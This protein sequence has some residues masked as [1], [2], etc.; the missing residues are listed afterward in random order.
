MGEDGDH[1]LRAARAALRRARRHL[2]A[3]DELAASRRY[4]QALSILILGLEEL[5]KA[6]FLRLVVEGLVSTAPETPAPLGRLKNRDLRLHWLK[7]KAIGALVTGVYV[8]ARLNMLFLKFE[9]REP[10]DTEVDL[11]LPRILEI[12][13]KLPP[14]ATYRKAQHKELWRIARDLRRVSKLL[15]SLE[16]TKQAG[17]YVDIDLRGGPSQ[18]PRR[19]ARTD[20]R[21][22]RGLA[23]GVFP[24]AGGIV[25]YG[26]TETG[27]AHILELVLTGKTDWTED[28]ATPSGHPP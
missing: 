28:S 16:E 10:T 25:E 11:L 13:T 20:H 3:S 4:G 6:I 5:G 24:F 12:A 23:N 14:A 19:N 8:R 7:Q 2:K 9:G 22:L 26:Y 17:F 27:R 1:Q 15:H 21:L 18:S